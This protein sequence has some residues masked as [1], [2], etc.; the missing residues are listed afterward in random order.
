VVVVEEEEDFKVVEVV[1]VET[2]EA[3][4]RE[5]GIKVVEVATR[6]EVAATVVV[7]IKVKME[8]MEEVITVEVV[9]RIEEVVVMEVVTRIGGAVTRIEVV[10]VV[11]E[12]AIKIEGAVI[13]IEEV[14]VVVVMVGAT[15]IEGV[16]E[17][18]AVVAEG[19]T[20]TINISDFPSPASFVKVCDMLCLNN[21]SALACKHHLNFEA[22]PS[23]QS[24]L[25]ILIVRV[26]SIITS[27][28]KDCGSFLTWHIICMVSM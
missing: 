5:D 12:V 13:R 26:S 22:L 27:E 25:N 3:E 17:E 19:E 4:F 14:V 23:M 10:V 2:E 11:T 6:T 24:T 28:R 16:A 9:I 7:A 21:C 8:D 1:G 18:G 15:R 20:V